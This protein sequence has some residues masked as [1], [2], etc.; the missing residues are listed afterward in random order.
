MK[1]FTMYAA[2]IIAITFVFHS[3]ETLAK[4]V[5]K[6]NH[7]YPADTTLSKLDQWFADEI[8]TATNSEI[9]IRIVWSN[10]LGD[11][12]Q[13]LPM[14]KNGII[15]MAAMSAGYFSKELPFLSAPNALP[16]AMDNVCQASEIMKALMEKVPAFAE[17]ASQNGI[18]P[19]FFHLINPCLLTS[20][21]PI[22]K[23]SDLKDKRVRTWGDSDYMPMVVKAAGATPVPLF[24]PD[25]YEGLKRGIIDIC[26][27]SVDLTE[28]YKL[29]EL[30]KH[31]SEV[32]LWEGPTAGIWISEKIWKTLSPAHQKILLDSAEKARQKEIPMMLEAD[33][34]ARESLKAKGVTFHKFPDEELAAWKK[35]SPDFF[36]EWINRMDKLGKKEA[37]E[38]AVRLWKEIR[39]AIVQCPK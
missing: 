8:R 36:Q 9:E 13:N 2:I 24:L 25:M 4:T 32:A 15:D 30:A 35:A 29:Y 20:K 6:M 28:T 17:E 22:T 12:K 14:L 27:L 3:P 33:R 16:M 26:P 23:F 10:G 7:Q 37:A 11:A 1:R 5:L 34:L 31:I 21:T 38:Q 18:R 19:L 39:A